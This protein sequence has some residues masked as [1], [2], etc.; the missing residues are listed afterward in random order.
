MVKAFEVGPPAES[1]NLALDQ[2]YG[3]WSARRDKRTT[4]SLTAEAGGTLS[5]TST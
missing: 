3:G 4:T 5:T 2:P 1:W